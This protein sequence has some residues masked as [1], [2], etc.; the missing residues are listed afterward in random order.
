MAALYPEEANDLLEEILTLAQKELFDHIVQE[1]V[2]TTA[3]DY[4][5]FGWTRMLQAVFDLMSPDD[6]EAIV[7]RYKHLR[8]H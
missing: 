7:S 1:S 3:V 8:Y 5:T 2:L 6:L 4:I